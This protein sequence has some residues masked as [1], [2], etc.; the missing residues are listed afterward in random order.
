MRFLPLLFAGVGGTILF[1][2]MQKDVPVRAVNGLQGPPNDPS[3]VFI[4]RFS[5]GSEQWSHGWTKTRYGWA[6]V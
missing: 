2:L 1:A 6:M 5:D 4:R 3:A